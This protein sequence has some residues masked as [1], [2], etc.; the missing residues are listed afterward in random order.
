M[1]RSFGKSVFQSSARLENRFPICLIARK[2]RFPF[3][4]IARTIKNPFI[5]WARHKT[6]VRSFGKPVFHVSARPDNNFPLFLLFPKRDLPVV[7]HFP[8]H[9]KNQFSILPL[10]R[11]ISFPLLS[12]FGNQFSIF[13]LVRKSSFPCFRSLRKTCC[14]FC[15]SLGKS[16]LI[17]SARSEKTN[18]I[19]PPTRPFKDPWKLPGALK[20]PWE[21]PETFKDPWELP[22]AFGTPK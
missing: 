22:G 19:I 2:F 13:P 4:P 18:S 7:Y 8:D 10:A 17:F 21:F 1:C 5:R 12:S 3:F 6:R 16:I 20:Y 9:S 15:R 11:K 14:P